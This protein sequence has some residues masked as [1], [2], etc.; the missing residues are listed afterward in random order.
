MSLP[1]HTS[2]YSDKTSLRPM[3]EARRSIMG[4][5]MLPKKGHVDLSPATTTN[6]MVPSSLKLQQYRELKALQKTQSESYMFKQYVMNLKSI[7]DS[8]GVVT[9][10]LDQI[11]GDHDKLY[12]QNR[13]RWKDEYFQ[14]L[15]YYQLRRYMNSRFDEDSKW[16][17]FK[18][19]CLVISV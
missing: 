11:I 9:Q 1:I 16:Y 4:Y 13:Q 3:K 7:P 10:E 14:T 2:V 17:A 12:H 6:Y 5:C 15:P 19:F 18:E 8:V